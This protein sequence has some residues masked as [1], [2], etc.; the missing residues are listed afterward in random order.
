MLQARI[1]GPGDVRL[2]EVPEPIT[3]HQPGA[4]VTHRLQTLQL[5]GQR[6]R[7]RLTR[8]LF[9]TGGLRQQQPGFQI[10]QP[11]GHHQVF[12]GEF[13]IGPSGLGDEPQILFGQ[14]PGGS[15][16]V[17]RRTAR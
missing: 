7:H 9:G 6:S 2:D 10:G 17:A 15:S 13:Q 5:K 8:R 3:G 4:D 16:A 11:C 12:G 1:H 14:L